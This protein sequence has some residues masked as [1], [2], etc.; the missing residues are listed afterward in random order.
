MSKRAQKK[1]AKA[2]PAKKAAKKPAAE[3]RGPAQ[4]GSQR[5]R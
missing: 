1:P 2:A 3:G 4:K 5:P